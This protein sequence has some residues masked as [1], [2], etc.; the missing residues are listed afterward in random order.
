MKAI[1]LSAGLGTRL[2]P[3][4]EYLPKPLFPVCGRPIIDT[5]IRKLISAGITAVAVNT[6]HLA[7]Q[8]ESF[9]KD[10]SYGIDILVR[11]EPSLL[12]TGGAI[13]N[14][15]DFLSDG[16]FIVINSDIL[17]DIDISDIFDTHNA[18]QYPVT[19][20]MHDYPLFNKVSV[21]QNEFVHGF[22]GQIQNDHKLLAFTGVSVID[23]T[24]YRFIQPDSACCIIDV[25]R[26]MIRS[27]EKIKARVLPN[28]TWNDL[29]TPERFRDA[30]AD[31][32]TPRVFSQVYGT[33]LPSGFEKKKLAGDGSQRKWY[34]ICKDDRSVIM[35][36]HGIHTESNAT[37]VDA[38]VAIGTHLYQNAIPVPEIYDFD[39][40]SG[41][42]F[43]QD[44]GDNH[45]QDIVSRC[46]D[47]EEIT[48]HYRNIIDLLVKMSVSGKK[49]FSPAWA[50]EGAQ[51]DKPLIIEKECRYF[52]N[53]FLKEYLGFTDLPASALAHEFEYLADTILGN[54]CFGLMH[55]DFQSRNIMVADKQYYFNDFQGARIGPIQYDLASLL[56]DPYVQIE[57]ETQ[58]KLIVYAE[59]RFNAHRPPGLNDHGQFLTGYRYCCI[60]RLMQAIGAYAFLSR[61][62]QK[63]W[64]E[65]YIPVALGRLNRHL[66]DLS[67]IHLYTLGKIV[68]AAEKNLHAKM[69]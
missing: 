32:M 33:S 66:D 42:V 18:H 59:N 29:G 5:V 55:R 56:V 60:A 67:D 65:P 45:L 62:M 9:L 27:G 53:R 16:P 11:H 23:P 49:G 21:C 35:A 41:L 28:L 61:I 12:G 6:H 44:L 25:F 10:R 50:Y 26:D 43:M 57:R 1:V 24:I 34:R 19:L 47:P 51:Y 52:T 30:V 64:F 39:R 58:E 3:H 2:K 20:A 69:Q 4:T 17:T 37:Q 63:P 46:N 8:I 68:A 14:F 31:D 36:D 48:A 15:S 40:F 7:E 22:S 38:F 13:G 54:A